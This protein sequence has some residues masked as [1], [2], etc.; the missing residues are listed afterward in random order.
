MPV[1]TASA[2]PT[3]SAPSTTFRNVRTDRHLDGQQAIIPS[4][5]APSAAPPLA[6]SST[7]ASPPPR[8]HGP[9][10]Q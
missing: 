7:A 2:L 4:P 6:R 8:T 5:R 1:C 3:P 9:S 10:C